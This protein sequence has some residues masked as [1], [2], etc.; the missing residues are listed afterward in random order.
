VLSWASWAKYYKVVRLLLKYKA[1]INARDNDGRTALH[2]AAEKGH[3]G[4]VWLLLEHNANV[5]AEDTDRRTALYMAADKG[6]E[7]VVRLLLKYHNLEPLTR[8]PSEYHPAASQAMLVKLGSTAPGLSPR[9]VRTR[10]T[11]PEV[12]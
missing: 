9:L 4:V 12:F 5:N 7:A 8:P 6:H 11:R 10:F 1:D 2:R 3:K